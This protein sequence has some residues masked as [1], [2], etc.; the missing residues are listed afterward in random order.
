MKRIEGTHDL[1]QPYLRMWCGLVALYFEELLLKLIYLR[2]TG[3]TQSAK[4]MLPEATAHNV[5]KTNVTFCIVRPS[6]LLLVIN[7]QSLV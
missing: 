3:R 5:A 4:R 1:L 7:L 6:F 2:I